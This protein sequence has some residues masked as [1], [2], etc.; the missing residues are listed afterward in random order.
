MEEQGK[1]GVT[2]MVTPHVDKAKKFREIVTEMA[3]LYER[4]NKDYGDS[5]GQTFKE[6]GA[7]ASTMRLGDKL[8]R[9]KQLLKSGE[10][11]VK[12]ESVIDTLTDLACYA[13]MLRIE[14]EGDK[15]EH[16]DES[17]KR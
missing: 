5:F 7:Y 10:A 16:T 2:C 1:Y 8:S 14:L 15:S 11:E 12:T 9:A 13:I 17:E 6:Y 3:D 4:K